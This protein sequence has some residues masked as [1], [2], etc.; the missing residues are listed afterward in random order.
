MYMLVP[1]LVMHCSETHV[2]VM[3]AEQHEHEL[4]GITIDMVDVHLGL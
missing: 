3:L 4:D 2:T 1:V